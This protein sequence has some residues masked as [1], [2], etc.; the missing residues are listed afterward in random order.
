MSVF[1]SYKYDILTPVFALMLI[2]QLLN[3]NYT[4]LI[5]SW[6]NIG[7]LFI[8]IFMMCGIIRLLSG[9]KKP[10]QSEIYLL[11]LIY[12]YLISQIISVYFSLDNFLAIKSL[13]TFGLQ[14][15]LIFI[16]I[17]TWRFEWIDT[18]LNSLI[19]LFF[20]ISFVNLLNAYAPGFDFFRVRDAVGRNFYLYQFDAKRVVSFTNVYAQF[21]SFLFM[22]GFLALDKITTYY[23]CRCNKNSNKIRS[24]G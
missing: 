23:L 8:A 4:I 21:A 22:G 13:L 11:F 17:F 10:S 16:L 7:K 1:N 6:L 24:S 15:I 5:A 19:L 2:S 18:S 12:L 3:N 20:I 9:H 14:F